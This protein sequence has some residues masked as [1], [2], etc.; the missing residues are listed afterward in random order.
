VNVS[1]TIHSQKRGGEGDRLAQDDG[2]GVEGL[3]RRGGEQAGILSRG[4]RRGWSGFGGAAG[5]SNEKNAAQG[6]G[7]YDS[8]TTNGLPPNLALISGTAATASALVAYSPTRT[9]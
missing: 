6:G 7:T 9:L 5:R 1:D 4:R 8:A 2:K 3:G